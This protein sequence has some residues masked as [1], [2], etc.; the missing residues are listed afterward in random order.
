MAFFR[1]D[2]CHSMLLFNTQSLQGFYKYH[3]IFQNFRLGFAL[4]TV[5]V[6]SNPKHLQNEKN[7]L[8]VVFRFFDG[9]H[10]VNLFWF[11]SYFIL[12]HNSSLNF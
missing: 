12:I 7:K 1:K 10:V 5:T 11:D 8:E 2:N 9:S 6:K 4:R 3:N